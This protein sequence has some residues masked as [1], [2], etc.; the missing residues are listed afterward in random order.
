MNKQKFSSEIYEIFKKQFKIKANPSKVDLFFLEKTRKYLNFIKWIPGIKM[1]WIW[2]SISMNAWKKNSDIDLFIITSKNRL[3]L[4]RILITFIF[5]ILWVRKTEKKHAWRFCLSFFAS[6]NA[7][8]FSNFALENDIYLYFRTIYFKPIL[9][10]DNTYEN[11]INQNKSWADFDNYT[12]IIN[13]NKKNIKITWKSFW[14]KCRILD[15]IEKILK[16]IFLIRT[17]KTYENLWKPFWV[18]INDYMLKFHD[19]DI[20]KKISSDF[21]SLQK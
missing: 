12:E 4:V 2:N 1:I 16:K 10:F 8:N 5:Q 11:F 19:K 20:R 15:I 3:W 18:I 21:L 14:D 13:Q 17:L 9:D 6:E 7:L